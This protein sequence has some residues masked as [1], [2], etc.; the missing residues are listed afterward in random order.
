MRVS[1][2]LA[3]NSGNIIKLE[4]NQF[5]KPNDTPPSARSWTSCGRTAIPSRRS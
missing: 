3:R 2:L 4:H 5:V 1:G